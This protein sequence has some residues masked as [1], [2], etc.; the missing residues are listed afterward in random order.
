MTSVA[1]IVKTL[2]KVNRGGDP[3]SLS[4]YN[5]ASGIHRTP[6]ETTFEDLQ[7]ALKISKLEARQFA[8]DIESVGI[9]TRIFGRRSFKSRIKWKYT[10]QSIAQ[11]A[12]EQIDTL[13]VVS[14]KG[15][16]M[17]AESGE[18]IGSVN[19]ADDVEHT[20]QLRSG[21]RV[22]FRLPRDLTTR[23]AD[24]LAAFIKT[25]PLE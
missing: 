13:E 10:L 8:A 20:F 15:F 5:W 1:R 16:A 14:D 23:E 24:R 6:R 25:L 4:F 22:H 2:R 3:T 19:D 12:R 9:G 11:A 7:A 17:A 21:K 18:T